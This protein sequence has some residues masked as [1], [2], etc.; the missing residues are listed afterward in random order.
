MRAC[1]AHRHG[2]RS[3]TVR[4]VSPTPKIYSVSTKREG[5]AEGF[6]GRHPEIKKAAKNCG[7]AVYWGDEPAIRS[8]CHCGT[9]WAHRGETPVIKAAGARFSVNAPSTVCGKRRMRFMAADKTCTIPVFIDSLKKIAF[10]AERTGV[11]YSK[12]GIQCV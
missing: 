5:G 9:T 1:P 3:K 10:Q 11:S 8:D 7:A 4:I 2:A 12:M 6:K